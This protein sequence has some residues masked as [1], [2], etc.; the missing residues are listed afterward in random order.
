[1]HQLTRNLNFYQWLN[2][3]PNSSVSQ[4]D[5]I[6]NLNFLD[7]EIAR[8]QDILC[9]DYEKWLTKMTYMK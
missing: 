7:E 9:I 2:D 6:E 3:T 8:W 5:H 1:M 4:D